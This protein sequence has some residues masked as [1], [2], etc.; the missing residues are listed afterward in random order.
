MRAFPSWQVL[1]LLAGIS[2]GLACAPAAAEA[3]A[4]Q[5]LQ[6]PWIGAV[7]GDSHRSEIDQLLASSASLTGAAEL[8]GQGPSGRASAR[9]ETMFSSQAGS[10]PFE[11]FVKNSDLFRQIANYQ[12]QHPRILEVRGGSITLEQLV[13]AIGNA[14]V[15]RSHKD[16]YLLSY[17][18]LI[19]PNAELR[20]DGTRLYL[21]SHSGAALINQGRLVL[22]N[23]HLESWSGDN[24]SDESAYRSFVMAWAGSTTLIEGSTLTRLG[25]NSHLSRGL[26]TGRSDQQGPGVA[27]A[28][29]L[30][31]KSRFSDMAN[32]IELRQSLAVVEDSQFLDLQLYAI[33]ILDSRV[34][35]TDNHV[36]G[37]R[38]NSG[39]RVRGQGHSALRRNSVLGTA[40]SGLE[41][42]G[43]EG[44]LVANNNT[45]GKNGSNGIQ[46]RQLGA[47]SLVLLA[48]NLISNPGRTGIDADVF[49]QLLISGNSIG[50]SPEYGLYLRNAAAGEGRAVVVGNRFSGIGMSM[51]KSEGV[52]RLVLGNNQFKT[53]AGR[54][55]VLAGDLLPAQSSVM[56]ATVSRPCFVEVRIG[57]GGTEEAAGTLDCGSGS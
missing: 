15:L 37:V 55:T 44:V 30:V 40:K 49:G 5:G 16:G 9:L 47:G 20:L 8:R 29:L 39:F 54:Q 19:A 42:S 34:T 13:A 12:A 22:N 11:P 53:R 4:V 7:S 33:D 17:P 56:D 18:L 24:A 28:R 51:I 10:W 26:T 38:T 2:G 35:I 32:G 31:S 3:V 41:T 14:Q 21:N 36:D 6:Q 45:F 50:N 1:T 27:P 48:D 52:G 46:L 23:A 43:F 25:H 57:G